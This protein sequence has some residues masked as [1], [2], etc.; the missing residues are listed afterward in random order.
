L[1]KDSLALVQVPDLLRV[2]EP[3]SL[4]ERFAARKAN[5]LSGNKDFL[6]VKG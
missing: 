6:S 5:M 3:E 1:Q 2:L 4:F